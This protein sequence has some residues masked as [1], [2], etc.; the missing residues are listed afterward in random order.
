MNLR[1]R[2]LQQERE[3]LTKA[4]AKHRW[5][6]AAAADELGMLRTTLW[7]KLKRLGIARPNG[8]MGTPRPRR[9]NKCAPSKT[10]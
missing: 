2:L 9:K 4:V 5:N 1:E 8:M 3:I 7:E 6:V 10:T